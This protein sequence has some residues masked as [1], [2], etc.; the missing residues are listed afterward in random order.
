MTVVDDR[1]SK[2]KRKME[3]LKDFR[4]AVLAKAKVPGGW[5]CE[6]C[7]RVFRNENQIEAHHK[8]PRSQGG[9]NCVGNGHA[10]CRTFGEISCHEAVEL[11]IDDGLSPWWE[12]ITVRNTFRVHKKAG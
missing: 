4:R 9:S 12:W 5:K 11:H 7:K 3:A 2:R 1:A 10:L 8:L 6:R